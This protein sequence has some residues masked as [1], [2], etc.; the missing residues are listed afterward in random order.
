LYRTVPKGA[1]P[2][3]IFDRAY[4]LLIAIL[5]AVLLP[6]DND[7]LSEPI[8]FIIAILNLDNLDIVNKIPWAKVYSF[9]N[10]LR[11]SYRAIGYKELE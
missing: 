1:D 3:S 4:S 6:K 2:L 5:E 10:T 11:A 8:P 9:I 7:V